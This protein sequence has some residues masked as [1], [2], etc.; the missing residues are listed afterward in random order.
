M[1]SV[2]GFLKPIIFLSL[3]FVLVGIAALW[4]APVGI[5]SDTLLACFIAGM[6]VWLA[7]GLGFVLVS[8]APNAQAR[9]NALLGGMLIRLAI[10]LAALAL[11][12]KSAEWLAPAGFAGFL[13]VFFLA[14]LLIETPMLVAMVRKADSA[15]KLPASDPSAKK[16]SE[17]NPASR[18]TTGHVAKGNAAKGVAL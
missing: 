12:P 10:P 9:L 13:L 3:A 1:T 6:L 2:S 16:A 5:S 15:A 17:S 18:S 8:L 4:L 7:G 14:G 11:G